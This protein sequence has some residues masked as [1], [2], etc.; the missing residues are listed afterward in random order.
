MYVLHSTRGNTEMLIDHTEKIEVTFTGDGFQVR[1]VT[2]IL[3]EPYYTFDYFIS[4][5]VLGALHKLH[6]LK[7]IRESGHAPR[8]P[9]NKEELLEVLAYIKND[10]IDI[11][12]EAEMW[13]TKESK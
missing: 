7:N 6:R 4:V 3:R 12:L 9:Y 8:G 5:P 10:E 1:K 2:S 13:I 11:G